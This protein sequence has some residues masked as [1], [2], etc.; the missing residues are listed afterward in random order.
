LWYSRIEEARKAMPQ[1]D[2]EGLL[3]RWGRE[4]IEVAGTNDELRKELAPDVAAAGWLGFPGATDEQIRSAEGRLG[5]ALPP[6]YREFLH[7][8]NGWRFPRSFLQRLWSVEEIDWLAAVDQEGI[9]A[10]ISGEEYIDIDHQMGAGRS[11]P[12]TSDAEYFSYDAEG[13]ST[14]TDMRSAYLQ[15]ALAISEREVIGTGV[16]LLMPQ[17]V[18][19]EGEWEAWFWAHW[20]PGAVRYRTFWDMLRDQY[21]T[22]IRLK[23]KP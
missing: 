4:L 13:K 22:D 15:G 7:I 19:P 17:V 16:Y 14:S 1:Y 5:R 20:I 2:W 8:T 21:A 18:T 23:R 9:D 11:T 10:W 3:S 6:S 12:T